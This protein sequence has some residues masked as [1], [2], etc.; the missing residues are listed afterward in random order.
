MASGAV[1]PAASCVIADAP[2][3]VSQSRG[4]SR[5]GLITSAALGVCPRTLYVGGYSNTNSSNAQ[6]YGLSYVNGNN[7]VSN[8][9][10]NIGGRLSS[11]L[12][13][14]SITVNEAPSEDETQENQPCRAS[15]AFGTVRHENK[16][17]DMNRI[18]D[19]FRDVAS[20]ENV[21]QSAKRCCQSRRD[22][23]EVARFLVGRDAK[24]KE[25]QTLILSLTYT[26]SQYRFFERKENGKVRKIADLPLF[27]DRI[28]RQCFA[29]VVG[30]ALDK[31]LI[32]Q[33]HAS[34]PGHGIQSALT[35]ALQ[36]I[37]RSPK[38]IYCLSLDIHKCYESIDTV[39]LKQ[40][41]A[42]NIKDKLVLRFLNQFID[43][44]PG[45]GISIGDSMSPILCNLYLSGLDH[46]AKEILKCHM[47]IRYADNI[48]IFGNS[49]A[50][51]VQ[52]Q[53]KLDAAV[54]ELH[55]EFNSN[56]TIADLTKE[57]VDFLGFRLFKD[58][59]LLRKRTK[60]RMKRAIA[61]IDKKVESGQFPDTHDRGT[62]ASY[63]GLLKWCDSYNLYRKTIWPV[64]MKI[65]YLERELKGAKSFRRFMQMN[66]V[67]I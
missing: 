6:N 58:H 59:V 18:G 1:I 62:I 3:H 2:L 39:L 10:A 63:K 36:Y 44:Y 24:M 31:K 64:E 15:T 7:D 35:Q 60:V 27:P 61:R 37:G 26:T 28:I 5:M 25:V 23:M 45:P 13:N 50:W 12:M 34:R 14:P 11:V 22:K 16:G 53:Q 17:Y 46:Y 54:H 30:P 29:S 33:T 51:L 32:E 40:I 43:D 65:A 21:E 57:G 49:K 20:S 52:I 67:M 8:A 56:W 66:E 9:N 47:Y 19:M 42:R 4:Y 38:T 41:L 55:L 48:Y